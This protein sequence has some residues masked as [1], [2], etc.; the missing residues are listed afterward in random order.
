MKFYREKKTNYW[1]KIINKKITA[2]YS[3]D[4]VM[5]FKNGL[6]HNT[7]NASYIKYDGTK[8]FYLNYQYYGKEYK[9]TK[10]S[11]RRFC[12]LQTFL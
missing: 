2:I 4:F 9:F 10:Q 11:W 5:F 1:Y 3:R 8:I 12:K 7:K 6:Y